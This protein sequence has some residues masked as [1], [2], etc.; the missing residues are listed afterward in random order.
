MRRKTLLNNL[1]N[2]FRMERSAVESWLQ[3]SDIE[4]TRRGETLTLK[5]YINLTKNYPV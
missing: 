4:T 2:T 1:M 5:E 3:A